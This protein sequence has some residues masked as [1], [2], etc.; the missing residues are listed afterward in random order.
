MGQIQRDELIDLIEAGPKEDMKLWLKA[1]IVHEDSQAKTKA[2]CGDFSNRFDMLWVFVYREDVEPTNNAA[3]R[4][5]R[6][7]VIWRKL[8][9]GTQSEAGERFVERV[10]TVG[11]TLKLRAKNTFEYFTECFKALIRGGQSPPVFSI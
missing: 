5:L 7:G 9:Y 11:M 4:S 1:G 6:F 3:E 8:S 10:M 2:T